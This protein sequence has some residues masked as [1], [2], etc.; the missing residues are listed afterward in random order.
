MKKISVISLIL[1]LTM[2][3]AV[4]SGCGKKEETD[5]PDGMKLAS[6]EKVDYYMY[7]PETWKVDNSE[8]YTAAYFSSGDATS[9]SA[10]AYGISVEIATVDDWW[11]LFEE[12][13]AGVYS[14]IS[15]ITAA[16]AAIDGIKGRE[17]TF[18]ATLGEQE[19]N[20][21]ITAVIKDYYVYYITYTSIPEYNEDHLE[22]R[23]QV[24]DAFRFKD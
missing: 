15:E 24:I 9:I 19:Y 16:D 2:C 18:S 1:V 17:Y 5:A 8:L 3:V 21:I 6:G 23:V 12:E 4:F 10:T 20:F 7:V 11:K 14:E 13:M 22:E